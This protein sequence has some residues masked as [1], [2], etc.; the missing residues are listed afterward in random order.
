MNNFQD[1]GGRGEGFE[2]GL[3]AVDRRLRRV[4]EEIEVATVGRQANVPCDL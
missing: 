3:R 1:R 4:G 2:A